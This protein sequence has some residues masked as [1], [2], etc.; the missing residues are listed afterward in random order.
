[1]CLC[2]RACGC[3]CLWMN[4]CVQVNVG[5][6]LLLLQLVYFEIGSSH[7]TRSSP[8]HLNSWTTNPW[9]SAC[10]YSS[11]IRLQMFFCSSWLLCGCWGLQ[12]RSS[13]LHCKHFIHRASFLVPHKDV[14][15]AKYYNGNIDQFLLKITTSPNVI[16]PSEPLKL[17]SGYLLGHHIKCNVVILGYGGNMS[18]ILT[19]VYLA[20]VSLA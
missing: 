13:C 10:L 19:L 9:G 6:L 11:V 2:T 12:L 7:W 4:M 15:M 18:I 8:F 17:V 1:M 5:C 20:S 3:T 16:K 14:S